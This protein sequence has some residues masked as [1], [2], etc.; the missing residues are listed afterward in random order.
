MIGN[1]GST[2]RRPRAGQ[3][4]PRGENDRPRPP[5]PEQK[6]ATTWNGY[7]VHLTETC[8]ADGPN[9]ITDVQTTVA[10]TPDGQ[11]TLPIQAALAVRQL[12]PAEQY[13]DCA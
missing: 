9:L 3:V 8:D 12:L 10:T 11:L 5:G 6:R 4:R 13:V 2:A 7:K 1:N